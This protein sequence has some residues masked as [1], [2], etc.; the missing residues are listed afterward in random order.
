M[1]VMFIHLQ[2]YFRNYFF[3][4]ADF[5]FDWLNFFKIWSNWFD[6]TKIL[7]IK[8]WVSFCCCYGKKI[9]GIFLIF[10][11]PTP[12]FQST[13]PTP[14][15]LWTHATHAKTLTHANHVTVLTHGTHAIHAKVWP[16]PSTNPRTHTTNATYAPTLPMSPTL[17]SRWKL[18]IHNPKNSRV[19]CVWSS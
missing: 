8:R 17:F 15:T 16:T 10:Y 9:I 14:K 13:P 11:G 12:R 5:S 18:H 6:R 3:T 7:N 19:I 2:F 1:S 4:R